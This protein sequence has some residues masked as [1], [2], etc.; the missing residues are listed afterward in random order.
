MRLSEHICARYQYAVE[1]I[2][3]RWTTLI[4]KVLLAGPLHFNQIGTQLEV[5]SDRVLSERLKE[6]EKE[7]IV[8]RTVCVGPPIRVTYGLTEKGAALAPICEAIETWSHTWV[9]LDA[10]AHPDA[11]IE[12]IDLAEIETPASEL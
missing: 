3:R 9:T 7:G 11:D 2:S 8:S 10:A 12:L 6:L 5:V 4:I 1:I